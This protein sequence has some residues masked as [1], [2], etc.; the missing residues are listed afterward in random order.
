[1]M[2]AVKY[3]VATSLDGYIAGPNEEIDWLY[4]DGDYGWKDFYASIDT[5]LMGRKTHDIGIAHG[6]SVFA[7]K[8]NYVFSRHLTVDPR[9]EVEYVSGDPA[10]LV[11]RLKAEP[12]KDLWLVGGAGLAGRFFEQGLVDEVLVGIHPVI[13]GSGL[14]LVESGYLPRWLDFVSATPYDN[15]FI[16]LAYRVRP[17]PTP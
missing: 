11:H 3:F 5:V 12:G 13:L 8:K 16:A 7:G 2:R 1:M 17:V 14:P 15:G 4:T 9:G 10:P 6:M